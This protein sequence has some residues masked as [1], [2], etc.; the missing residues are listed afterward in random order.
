MVDTH[1]SK[2]CERKLMWVQVPLLAP[3]Y[4]FLGRLLV[5][6]TTMATRSS[7]DKIIIRTYNVITMKT[8][9]IS[10]GNSKGVRIPKPL[11][12]TSGLGGE[13]ELKVKLGEIRIIA[14]KPITGSLD[15]VLA[16]EKVLGKEW[17]RPEEKE[18]W[19]SLK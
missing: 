19:A 6:S 7:L 5:N 15:T 18:A 11:L 2:S 14:A 12:E 3:F 10:I 16:S 13:I 1:D 9:I 8:T 4:N 17:D